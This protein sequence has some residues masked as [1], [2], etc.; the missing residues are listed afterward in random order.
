[1]PEPLFRVGLVNCKDGCLAMFA[2]VNEQDTTIR[3]FVK[4]WSKENKET[5][6]QS[7][8]FAFDRIDSSITPLEEF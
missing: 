6:L 4:G 7:N 1:M 3:G 2:T 8:F 5:F